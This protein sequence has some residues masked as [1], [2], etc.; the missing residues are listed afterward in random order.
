MDRDDCQIPH[1]PRPDFV[2]GRSREALVYSF[3]YSVIE[4]ATVAIGPTTA[5]RVGAQRFHYEGARP[6]T[7][8]VRPCRLRSLRDREAHSAG[9]AS[10]VSISLASFSFKAIDRI[11]GNTSEVSRVLTATPTTTTVANGRCTSEPAPFDIAIGKKPRAATAPV[12]R[13]ARSAW[14]APSRIAFGKG[15]PSANAR[16]T[17]VV[18][19]TPFNTEMPPSA[20]KPTAAGKLNGKSRAKRP[21]IPPILASGARVNTANAR[22]AL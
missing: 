16:S 14:T 7:S 13:T 21:M 5:H 22:R 11:A 10:A 17:S 6:R 18:M 12:V 4:F 1:T 15:L 8:K 3:F 20:M 19:T 2:P 9:T